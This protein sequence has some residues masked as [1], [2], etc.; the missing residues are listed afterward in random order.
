VSDWTSQSAPASVMVMLAVA[1]VWIP[2]LISCCISVRPAVASRLVG[3]VLTHIPRRSRYNCGA[4]EALFQYIAPADWIA[5]ARF[6]GRVSYLIA[7][8]P[9]LPTE[10]AAFCIPG[11][12]QPILSFGPIARVPLQ[13]WDSGGSKLNPHSPDDAANLRAFATI[14]G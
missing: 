5:P 4:V 1:G 10:G 12:P 6:S 14:R 7:K 2:S 13:L 11:H 3:N 8:R 9:F